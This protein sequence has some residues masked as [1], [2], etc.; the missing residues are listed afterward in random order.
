[1]EIW[2]DDGQLKHRA[3][4]SN[5][6]EADGPLGRGVY[7]VVLNQDG[8]FDEHFIPATGSTQPAFTAK[9]IPGHWRTSSINDRANGF[10]HR[11]YARLLEG[12]IENALIR[13]GYDSSQVC[14]DVVVL[15]TASPS[16]RGTFATFVPGAQ[17]KYTAGWVKERNFLG[18]GSAW[19]S[20]KSTGTRTGPEVPGTG[21]A[22]K[23]YNGGLGRGDSYPIHLGIVRA[24]RK[25]HTKEAWR[26]LK[27]I[28][29]RNKNVNV[30]RENGKTL[31]MLTSVVVA[32]TVSARKD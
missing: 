1:M 27:A 2:G 31:Q 29:L 23:F 13:L 24:N 15:E 6:A 19:I 3:T 16:L 14:Q 9:G 5:A 18:I 17:H 8:T 32:P 11:I 4:L 20:H 26:Q 10:G 7:K 12:Q 25:E 28:L 21:F 22:P 30:E